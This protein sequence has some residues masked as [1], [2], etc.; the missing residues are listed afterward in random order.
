MKHLSEVFENEQEQLNEA[1]VVTIN[2]NDM[3][4]AQTEFKNGFKDTKLQKLFF[5]EK[6]KD[7]EPSKDKWFIPNVTTQYANSEEAIALYQ[8]EFGWLVEDSRIYV[9]VAKISPVIKGNPIQLK[10]YI[11]DENHERWM[12]IEELQEFNKKNRL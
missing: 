7:V 1:K 10:S 4:V 9:R 11:Y 6:F 12:S 8:K 5:Y 2:D 3:V